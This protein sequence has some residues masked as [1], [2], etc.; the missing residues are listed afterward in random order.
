MVISPGPYFLRFLLSLL[1]RAPQV[2]R[3]L[4]DRLDVRSEEEEEEEEEWGDP[5]STFTLLRDITS[6]L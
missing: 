2:G 4:L 5:D 1:C 3:A 6:I